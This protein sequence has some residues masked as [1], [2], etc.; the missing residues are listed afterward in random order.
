M[1][2]LYANTFSTTAADANTV[3]EK[4]IMNLISNGKWEREINYLRTLSEQEY[5]NQKRNLVAVTWSGVFA[6]RKITG[7]QN[8]SGIVCLDIDNI[9][10]DQIRTLKNSFGY[11]PHVMFAF[12]SP[13]GKGIKILIKVNTG[14]EHHTAAFLHLQNVFE[15]QYLLKVDPSGKDVSRLCYVSFDPHSYYSENAKVFEVD[16]RF[17]EITKSYTPNPNFVNYKASSDSRRI[18]DVCTKWV[19]RT[20]QY[21]SGQRNRY[22]HAMACALN[23]CGMNMDDAEAM[24]DNEFR[25][26]E[27][28]EVK[29][30]VKSAYFHNQHEHGAVVVNEMSAVE[31]FVAPPYIA[32]YND[33]VVKNDLM[34]ITAMLE[35]HGVARKDVGDV[36]SKVAKY[37]KGMGYID[38]NKNSLLDL[39]NQANQLMLQNVAKIS[40]KNT[41]KYKNAEDMG[42]SLLDMQFNEGAITGI[43]AIDNA[44]RGAFQPGDMYE[45]I[46]MGSTFKSVLLLYIMYVNA[47][48]GIPSLYLNGEMSELQLHR[49]MVLVVMNLIWDDL[50]DSG[51]VNSGNIK[52]FMAQMNAIIKNNIFVYNGSGFNEEQ[53]IATVNSIEASSGKKI[54]VI[55]MDGLDQMDQLGLQEIPALIQNSKICKEVAKKTNSTV[56]TLVHMSGPAGDKTLRDTGQKVRGGVKTTANAD[57]Y[58]STSLLV[59]PATNDLTNESDVKYITGKFFLKFVD[60]RGSSGVTDVIVNVNHQLHLE[61]EYCDPQQYEIRIN[62]R[63]P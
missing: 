36:V 58:F 41:L 24:L 49:R 2:S 54:Q 7:L 17:A 8:Y 39:M 51:Q 35:Y 53:I 11:D 61:M 48:R 42:A 57:G 59:D 1:I 56:L 14:P 3:D 40:E 23:R 47:L 6:E 26:L 10:Y 4:E 9:D 31:D 37:Y 45:I 18:F 52:D 34:R 44:L 20:M 55:G 30:C 28:G 25:D 46:G 60:K 16:T 29:G 19:N 62:R 22:V 32:N 12:E 27:P 21:A 33:D 15:N 50:R 38:L 63:R 5:K 13:S 43:K